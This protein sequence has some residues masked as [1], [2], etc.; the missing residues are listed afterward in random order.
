MHPFVM[1]FFMRTLL[2]QDKFKI[3]FRDDFTCQ[4]CGSRSGNDNIEI[5]H[6]I[7]VSKHGSDNEENLV[8]ACKKCNRNKSNMVAFPK[9]MCE[10][11][12]RIDAEWTVHRSFGEWQVKFHPEHGA[13]LEYTPY[14]YWIGANRSHEPDWESHIM[15]KRWS[16][17]HKD[18]DFI[19]ALVYFRRMTKSA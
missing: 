4:F 9:S 19:E 8:A 11:V 17:P 2:S 13:V 1:R 15:S 10:G 7:P 5:E 18:S 12:D 16:E 6:L 3:A 14:G